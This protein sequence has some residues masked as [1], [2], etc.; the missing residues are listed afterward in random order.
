MYAE[1]FRYHQL[2]EPWFSSLLPSSV[3]SPTKASFAILLPYTIWRH[4]PA[5]SPPPRICLYI[6]FGTATVTILQQV[7]FMLYQND[8]LIF[9]GYPRAYLHCEDGGEG[10][11][12]KNGG[13]QGDGSEETEKVVTIRVVL[14]RPM[15]L[16]AGQYVNLWVPT[17]SLFS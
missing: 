17:V 8:A 15:K 13:A 11:E 4:L 12:G 6:S 1:I 7:G 5:D 16:D 9:R 14:T 2:L 3:R 10:E